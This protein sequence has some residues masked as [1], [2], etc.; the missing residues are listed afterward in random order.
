MTAN[1]MY[2]SSLLKPAVCAVRT[3]PHFLVLAGGEIAS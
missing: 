2:T 3:I 1:L